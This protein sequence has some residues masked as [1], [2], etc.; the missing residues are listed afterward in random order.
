MHVKVFILPLPSSPVIIAGVSS[1]AA[2]VHANP[3]VDVF[4]G[5]LDSGYLV[6]GADVVCPG[7]DQVLG[8][9]VVTISEATA[10]RR[11]AIQ[12]A[13]LGLAQIARL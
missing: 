5:E 12:R 7:S 2:A 4:I 9:D 10:S 3:P 1:T 11:L 13:T 8:L 6:M